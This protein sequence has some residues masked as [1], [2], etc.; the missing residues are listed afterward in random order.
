MPVTGTDDPMWL[1]HYQRFPLSNL[2]TLGDINF[3]LD[4]LRGRPFDIQGGDAMVLSLS[5]IFFSSKIHWWEFSFFVSP[6]EQYYFFLTGYIEQKCFLDLLSF[7]GIWL[8][9]TCTIKNPPLKHTYN[10]YLFKNGIAFPNL[11]RDKLLG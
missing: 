1:I 8:H 9:D 4:L 2:R 5:K 11:E 7:K 10:E 6:K 3:K